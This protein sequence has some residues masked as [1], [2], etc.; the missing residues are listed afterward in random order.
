MC[1]A[2]FKPQSG[3]VYV[4]P[5]A[6]KEAELLGLG[7]P[8]LSTRQ[9]S[10]VEELK[11]FAKDASVKHFL[12]QQNLAHQQNQLKVQQYAQALSLMA[13]V[14]IGS[15]SFEVREDQI[16]ETFSSFGPIKS[17]NMSWDALTGHHKGFAFLEFEVPEAA[18]LAQET[19]NGRLMGGRNLKVG[20][21]SNIP[22]AQPIIEM[23]MNEAKN[24]HRVYVASVH[25]DLSET[26]LIDVFTAFGV[27]TKCQLAKQL[28]GKGHRGFGYLEFESASAAAEAIV[29]M[30]LFDLGGMPLRVGKCITPP[31]ALTYVIPSSQSNLPAGT[32]MAAASVTAAIKEKEHVNRTA[33][34]SP[35]SSN[36]SSSRENS[37]PPSVSDNSND[38]PPTTNKR[39]RRGFGDQV[40]AVPPPKVVANPIAIT[41]TPL[42]LSESISDLKN[43]SN[44][45]LRNGK[46]TTAPKVNQIPL[47]SSTV[48][49]W[50][51]STSYDKS[52]VITSEEDMDIEN[53]TGRSTFNSAETSNDLAICD[54]FEDKLAVLA[55]NKP[56][57][58][59]LEDGDE[60]KR[61]S[62]RG[63]R[64]GRSKKNEKN[65]QS[66][67]ETTESSVN[68][69]KTAGNLSDHIKETKANNEDVSIAQQE[70][71]EIRGNE[72]RYQL[73]NKLMEKIKSSVVVL[74]NMVTPDEVDD[75]LDLEIRE[76]LSKFGKIDDIK[77]FKEPETDNIRIF[78][79]FKEASE[80]VNAKEQL[81]KRYFGGRTISAGIYD[82]GL[83]NHGD[84]NGKL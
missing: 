38:T 23:V 78:V 19:M 83:F 44:N 71:C 25:P 13:R 73:M 66:S 29:G 11:R 60:K 21:P 62:K 48:S 33:G 12:H 63:S 9:Q 72:Q 84:L 47:P 82:Q 37:L 28:G 3:L 1:A 64:G 39:K 34:T 52:K 41:H 18:I 17:I 22:Q 8:K 46:D 45:S 32:A 53:D 4:G 40:A 49:S 15:I 80:A 59:E 6:K 7:L 50:T 31:D 16:K 54:S 30:N 43:H 61:S 56:V 55:H 68:A 27:I 79:M 24:Y 69:A 65:D 5:G 81:D 77:F 20:K 57:K 10:D 26:D 75:N 70:K 51:T 14:Y 76:E 36:N 58:K 67:K 2:T 42:T 74:R 35:K